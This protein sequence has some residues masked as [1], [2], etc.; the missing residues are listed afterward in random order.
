M[1]LVFLCAATIIVVGFVVSFFLKEVPL[2]TMS[3]LDAERAEAALEA[4]GSQP[5]S[6]APTAVPAHA[7]GVAGSAPS[8]DGHVSAGAD[9]RSAAEQTTG[10][11]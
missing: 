5:S 11:P 10:G 6:S 1:D 9:G 7:D 8:S 4:A 3:G 2:R